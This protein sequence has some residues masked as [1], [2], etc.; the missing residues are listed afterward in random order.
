MSCCLI[1][2]L[3]LTC[4]FLHQKA[5]RWDK[6]QARAQLVANKVEGPVTRAVTHS[7]APGVHPLGYQLLM[8]FCR[9]DSGRPYQFRSPRLAS[10]LL[11]RRVA[12]TASSSTNPS[13]QATW[14]GLHAASDRGW[15][16][17]SP[18]LSRLRGA[19]APTSLVRSGRQVLRGSTGPFSRGRRRSRFRPPAGGS[20]SLPP[21]GYGSRPCCPEAGRHSQL[22]VQVGA[23]QQS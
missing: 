7:S 2:F 4:V 1:S 23:L 14:H 6:V 10:L 15:Q 16:R 20:P 17:W 11:K 18:F 12:T 13:H 9:C 5:A 3:I 8:L 22:G 21:V 19:A